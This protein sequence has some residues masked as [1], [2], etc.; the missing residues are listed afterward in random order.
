VK[1]LPPA[2]DAYEHCHWPQRFTSDKFVAKTNYADDG[3]NTPQTTVLLVNVGGRTWQ[4]SVGI[5]GRH[6]D[7]GSRVQY[8]ASDEQRQ[9]IPVVYYTDDKG[10]TTEFLSTDSKV[11]KGNSKK[12]RSGKWTALIATTAPRTL[13]KCPTTQ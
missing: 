7:D 10:K 3:K 6:L 12:G 9:V 4:G 5:H 1:N 2:R 13:L 8:I 11:P